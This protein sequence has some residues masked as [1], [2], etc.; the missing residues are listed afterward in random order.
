MKMRLVTKY[1]LAR[2]NLIAERDR[3]FRPGTSVVVTHD[4]Y[5]G[6]A[7]VKK[8]DGCPPDR[9][10]VIPSDR[11]CRNYQYYFPIESVELPSV[12]A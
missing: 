10:S 12:P 5:N 4:S 3:V 9:V 6:L 1:R 11:D 7:I 8:S 2:E